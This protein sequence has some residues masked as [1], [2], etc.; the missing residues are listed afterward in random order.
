MNKSELVTRMAERF[1]GDRATAVAAVDGVLE[2]IEGSVAR[3]ERVTLTGF[4]TFERRERAPR[5]GRNPRT[6]EAIQ[7]AASAVPAFRAGSTFRSVVSRSGAAPLEAPADGG[8]AAGEEAGDAGAAP[9]LL[10][11]QVPVPEPVDDGGGAAGNGTKGKK[12]ASG[13][14]SSAAA[15]PDLAAGKAGKKGGKKASKKAAGK[16]GKKARKASAQP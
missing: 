1:G 11:L 7:V 9:A 10:Q 14:G 2:E 6:G 16:G 8:V 5:T 3:G 12:K 4:G 13:A 15:V